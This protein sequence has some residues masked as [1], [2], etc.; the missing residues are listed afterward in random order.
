MRLHLGRK[1]N[2]WENIGISMFPHTV[3]CA[4]HIIFGFSSHL[5]ESIVPLIYNCK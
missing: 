3:A 5:K 4:F 1:I 2:S